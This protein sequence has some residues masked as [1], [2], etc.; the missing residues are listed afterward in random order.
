MVETYKN[1]DHGNKGY[2][3]FTEFES[4]VQVLMTEAAKR[5]N[6]EDPRHE[7]IE[8]SYALALRINPTRKGVSIEEW[9]TFLHALVDRTEWLQ[10]RDGG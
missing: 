2:L 9:E 3:V 10:A 1:C 4:Y 8:K 6:Y 7:T 5:G